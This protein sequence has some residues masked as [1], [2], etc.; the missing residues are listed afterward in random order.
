[1]R[2]K[3]VIF[4]LLQMKRPRPQNAEMKTSTLTAWICMMVHCGERCEAISEN[5]RIIS[6]LLWYEM[7]FV[8]IN[9]LLP[10]FAVMY[11]TKKIYVL[12]VVDGD[13]QFDA[14]SWKQCILGWLFRRNVVMT[15]TSWV[16]LATTVAHCITQAA[17]LED[18]SRINRSSPVW[19]HATN[20]TSQ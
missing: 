7:T 2:N 20:T 14:Q 19:T 13:E 18:D 17:H 1:M 5:I 12:R 8:V 16:L 9:A 3:I 6:W 11:Y 4:I 10:L 15:K